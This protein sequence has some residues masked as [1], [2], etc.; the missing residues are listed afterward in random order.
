[1]MGKS[2]QKLLLKGKWISEKKTVAIGKIWR[3]KLRKGLF[4][5]DFLCVR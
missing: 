2:M 1:M 4:W 5:K 3:Y